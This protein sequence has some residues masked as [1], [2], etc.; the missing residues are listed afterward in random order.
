VLDNG[1]NAYEGPG[2]DLLT[3][4]KVIELYLG[5]LAKQ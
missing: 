1:K 5:T 2:I 3:D 4:P